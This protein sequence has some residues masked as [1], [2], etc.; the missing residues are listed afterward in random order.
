MK[1]RKARTR[2]A[3]VEVASGGRMVTDNDEA[4]G[5]G[6]ARIGVEKRRSLGTVFT[7]FEPRTLRQSRER[8][9]GNSTIIMTL[10]ICLP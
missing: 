2:A 8:Q 1:R 5:L 6:Y 7:V 4:G 3:E 10:I 9:T